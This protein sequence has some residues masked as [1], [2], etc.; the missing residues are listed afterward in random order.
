MAGTRP[1]S[2]KEAAFPLR[3]NQWERIVFR[4]SAPV[5]INADK[6]MSRIRFI[7]KLI[8]CCTI[9]QRSHSHIQGAAMVQVVSCGACGEIGQALVQELWKRGDYRKSIVTD[10]DDAFLPETI[11]ALSAEHVQGDL[12]YKVKTFYDYDFD[13]I[14]HLAASL[15]RKPKWQRK[16]ASHQRRRDDATADA[17][18]VS[19]REIW[20]VRQVFISKFHRGVWDIEP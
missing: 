2:A 15:S 16:S 9:N 13:I 5:N 17:G 4:A 10:E 8:S 20:K 6:K 19:F 14:F 18:G 12:V 3:L 11:K 7:S 1:G